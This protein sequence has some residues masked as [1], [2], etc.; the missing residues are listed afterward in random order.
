MRN[1][2]KQLTKLTGIFILALFS[3][4][5]G[6]CQQNTGKGGKLS[7]DEFEQ[8]LSKTNAPQLID[9]RSA[10]EFMGGHLK[11]AVNININDGEFETK[12]A[13][14]NKKEPLFVYCLSGGRSANAASWF[15]KNGFETVYEMPGMLAWNSAGKEVVSGQ[16]EAPAKK[17]LSIDE[18]QKQVTSD[19]YVLVDFNAVWCKPCKVIG[20]MLDKVAESKKDK[21]ILIKIDADE[22]ADLLQQKQIDGIPYLELYKDG[23]LIWQHKG[24]IDEPTFLAETK[25]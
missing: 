11:N 5:F 24:M 10:E 4:N 23:K 19:K 20:P 17:G 22:N 6:S 12:A 25:L 7:V 3:L 9:V 8:K 18:Y 1:T 16:G 13:A 14:L 2:R 21:L 15:R